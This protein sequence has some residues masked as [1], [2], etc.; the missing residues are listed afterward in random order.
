MIFIGLLFG[1]GFDTAT[2]VGLFGIAGAEAARDWRSGS[3]S[4]FQRCSLPAC[5]SSTQPTASSWYAP[6]GGRSGTRSARSTIT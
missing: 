3:F 1:L 2:E 5:A 4:R 6:T